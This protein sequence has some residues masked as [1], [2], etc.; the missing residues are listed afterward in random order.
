[1]RLLIKFL[2]LSYFA[3]HEDTN[4]SRERCKDGSQTLTLLVFEYKQGAATNSS[5]RN[6]KA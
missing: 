2:A 1:L 4:E 5:Q 3:V 6:D